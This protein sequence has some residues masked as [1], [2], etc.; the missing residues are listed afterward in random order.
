[1]KTF[2][3]ILILAA[4]ALAGEQMPQ[5]QGN[6]YNL[7]GTPNGGQW[8]SGGPDPLQIDVDGFG[9]GTPAVFFW[10]NAALGGYQSRDGELRCFLTCVGHEPEGP[11][12]CWQYEIWAK[13][14]N[15]PFTWGK[16]ADGLMY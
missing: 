3:L 16:V 10:W 12:N 11:C 1:M 7:N 5:G 8:G 13:G 14:N 6:T 4:L 2:A 9:T 15:P